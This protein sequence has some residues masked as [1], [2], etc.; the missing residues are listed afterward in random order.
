[1]QSANHGLVDLAGREVEPGEVLVGR[2]IS[3]R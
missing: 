1:V 2:V 3:Q